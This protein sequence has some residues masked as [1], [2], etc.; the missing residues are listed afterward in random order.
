M[1]TQRTL[2]EH[3]S[4]ELFC[5]VF[6]Y[7]SPHDLL[8]AFND[9]NQR[10]TAIL[11]Q[12]PLCLP[13]NHRMSHELYNEYLASIIPNNMSRIVY[14][15]LSE[16]RAPHAVRLFL[17]KLPLEAVHWPALKAVT[18][19]DVAC[20]ILQCLLTTDSLLSNIHRLSI[21]IGF[22]QYHCDDYDFFDFN[23]LIPVLNYFPKLCS[24]YIRMPCHMNRKYGAHLKKYFLPMNIYQNMQT[25]TIDTCS[26]EIFVMLLSDGHL[27]Q[28]RRL[29]V[30]LSK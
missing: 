26:R 14:L 1:T 24:L 21:D 8:F 7:L 28:I 15:N 11:A 5:L 2:F 4:V 20:D 25:L 27:P 30:S 3:L 9:L 13:N 6:E 18:I 12:Q 19:E 23:L 17:S 29:C 10:F 16:L 22:K